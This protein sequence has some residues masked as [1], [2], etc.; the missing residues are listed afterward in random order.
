MSLW[1]V[2]LS[3]LSLQTTGISH[4]VLDFNIFSW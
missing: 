4:I 3:L 2:G 1:P